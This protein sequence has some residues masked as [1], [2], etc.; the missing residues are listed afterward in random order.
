MHNNI[1]SDN[2]V[3]VL[4]AISAFFADLAFS[5]GDTSTIPRTFFDLAK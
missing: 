2:K 4:E 3:F 1:G 5:S